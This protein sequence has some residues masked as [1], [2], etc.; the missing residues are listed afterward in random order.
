MAACSLL[1]APTLGDPIQTR[2]TAHPV[3]AGRPA[4]RVS[5][6]RALTS[7]SAP[8]SAAAQRS[9]RVRKSECAKSGGLE[10][11]SCLLKERC[12]AS[13]AK[14]RSPSKSLPDR[15]TDTRT[16]SGDRSCLSL[17]RGLEPPEGQR[18][19]MQQAS[20]QSAH[21]SAQPPMAMAHPNRSGRPASDELQPCAA[22][23]SSSPVSDQAAGSKRV[24]GQQ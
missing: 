23:R 5:G 18:A 16:A 8:G 4:K 13:E 24:C 1:E 7:H 12:E 10:S 3:A 22:N 19:M 14:A 11:E 17:S 20:K 21:A 6:L 2:T 15:R 9:K